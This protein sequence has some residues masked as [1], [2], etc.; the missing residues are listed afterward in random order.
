M[1]TSSPLGTAL[2]S[3]VTNVSYESV[4]TKKLRI[5]LASTTTS[6]NVLAINTDGSIGISSSVVP[7]SVGATSAVA[8]AN[9]ATITSGVIS[10]HDA[11]ATTP[12]I[13]STGLQ[14]FAGT[15][16]IPDGI[17]FNSTSILRNY[18]AFGVPF[19][20][21]SGPFAAPVGLVLNDSEYIASQAFINLPS[22]V[23]AATIPSVITLSPPLPVPLRPGT[24]RFVPIVVVDNGV[25]QLGLARIAT[26]GVVTIGADLALGPFSGAGTTGFLD[27]CLPYNV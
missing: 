1:F 12:G 15:K 19:T 10:L 14:S 26:T 24:I 4:T 18:Q 21:M 16:L 6:G 13:V 22:S 5:L 7:I 11:S 25:N 17:R 3:Q 27:C 23:S 20:T 8:T 2:G 9:G